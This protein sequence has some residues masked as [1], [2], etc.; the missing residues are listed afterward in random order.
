MNNVLDEDINYVLYSLSYFWVEVKYHGP[1]NKIKG[2]G[3][4]VDGKKI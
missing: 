4:F 1:S 3:S 2:I